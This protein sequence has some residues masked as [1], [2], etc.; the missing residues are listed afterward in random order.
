ME[1]SM[2]E[3]RMA[4]GVRVAYVTAALA[5]LAAA[6]AGAANFVVTNTSD[7]GATTGS[8]RWAVTQ[9]NATAGA[10]TIKF[11][12]PGTG[13][14]VITIASPLFLNDQVNV[15]GK[16]Q[17]GYAGS[18]LI[19]VQGT[20]SPAV[21]SLFVLFAS[22]PTTSSGSTIQGLG[23]WRYS[24]NSVTIFNV[25]SSNWVQD[26]WMGFFNDGVNPVLLNNALGGS[27]TLAR[28][29]ALQSSSN[30]IRGN[31]IA[32][33]DAG[34]AVGEDI[35]VP[36]P[37]AD[38]K[39]N[40]IQGNHIG[41]NPAG[42]SAA[43]YGT[44]SDAIF[45]ASGA[46]E[47]FIGPDNVLSGNGSAGVELLHPTVVGN[48]IF[49][50]RIGTDVTG[51]FAIPNTDAGV[52]IA[53]GANGNAVGGS[54]GGNVISGNPVAGV[55]LGTA[56]FPTAPGNWVQN[57]I[58]GLN[59][60][61]SGVPPGGGQPIGMSIETGSNRNVVEGNVIA[62]HSVHGVQLS[63]N[64]GNWVSYNWIGENS[65]GTPLGN[66]GYGIVFV[67]NSSYNFAEH[68]VFGVNSLGNIGQFSGSCCNV[69]VDP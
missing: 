8:L 42:T 48:V 40:S 33:V 34:I 9:A 13:V 27:F 16:S 29:M 62:G 35:S 46:R 47:N 54:W 4:R 67:N 5:C 65:S 36:T 11:K 58:I 38:Y 30:V 23:M 61:Q 68:N 25:S 3:L 51:M 53:N 44:T 17:P 66:G 50:N 57:N 32:G 10:D 2:K 64:N 52:L 19:Y 26:N 31:T 43:G 28:G 1:V 14:K 59:I 56:A 6:E 20:A 49:G 41:T 63:D 69:I 39:G 45:L 12:I 15:N 18:P 55:V 22:S 60:A 24:S 37:S 7:N 21:T